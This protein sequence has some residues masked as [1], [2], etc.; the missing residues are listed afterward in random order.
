[1]CFCF[2]PTF[3]QDDDQESMVMPNKN[4][5]N[6]ICFLPKVVKAKSEMPL[7]QLN[8]SSLIVETEKRVKLKTPDELLEELKDSCL[9]RVS[10]Y[11]Q[12]PSCTCSC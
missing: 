11:Y 7:T 5:E 8:V 6:Y 3:L 9:V 12:K 4:G 10:I 1:V 2:N